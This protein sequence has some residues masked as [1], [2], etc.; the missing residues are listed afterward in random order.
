M[1]VKLFYTEIDKLEGL[2]RADRIEDTAIG[3]GAVLGG[4]ESVQKATDSLRGR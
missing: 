2:S 4:N 1:Q 3:A